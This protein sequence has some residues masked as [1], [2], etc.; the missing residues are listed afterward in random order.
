LPVRPGW[1][2]TGLAAARSGPHGPGPT[3]GWPR[4][5]PPPPGSATAAR[6]RRQARWSWPASSPTHHPAPTPFR[7]LSLLSSVKTGQQ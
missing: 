3:A 6:S 7:S 5:C 2:S 1:S 4:Q